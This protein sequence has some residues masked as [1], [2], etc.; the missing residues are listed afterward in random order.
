MTPLGTS[1]TDLTQTVNAARGITVDSQGRAYVVGTATG[2]IYTTTGS[3]HPSV[4]GAQDA[5]IL[6][7]NTA[8]SGID[9]ST[10]LGGTENDQGLA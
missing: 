3:L 4:I 6:R 9:Y 2:N 8:G 10:Y 7:M 5:F 1:A